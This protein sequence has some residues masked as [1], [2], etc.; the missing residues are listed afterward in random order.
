MGASMRVQPALALYAN[1][2]NNNKQ[3]N[4]TKKSEMH[5][6]FCDRFLTFLSCKKTLKTNWRINMHYYDLAF[7][8]FSVVYMIAFATPFIFI[9]TW[10][11]E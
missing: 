9:L 7:G 6:Q 2:I 3:N 8:I 4:K 10:K 5:P 11:V 1:K